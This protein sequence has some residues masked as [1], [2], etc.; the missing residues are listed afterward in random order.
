MAQMVSHGFLPVWQ[1][2]HVSFQS[3]KGENFR[4]TIMRLL[5]GIT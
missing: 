5:A 3:A 4:Q 1:V 2:I